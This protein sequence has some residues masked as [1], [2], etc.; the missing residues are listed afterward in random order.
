M[1]AA[2]AP[3]VNDRHD[4]YASLRRPAFRWFIVSLLT[5]TVS[6]Q[7]Q[8]IVVS[9][10]IYDLTHDPL[11]LGLIG[12]AEALPFIGAALYAGHVADR[13]NR[14]RISIAALF[15]LVLC[16]ATRSEEPTS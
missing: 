8:A 12:L 15:V 10:Q 4:A 16:A 14:R 6:S 2:D 9:W 3:V 5:M 11:S 1:T 13:F 7:I